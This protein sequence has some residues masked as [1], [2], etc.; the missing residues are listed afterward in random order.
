MTRGG[1]PMT[2]DVLTH[3]LTDHLLSI[4]GIDLSNDAAVD[5]GLASFCGW[6]TKGT[7]YAIIKRRS[8]VLEIARNRVVVAII[9]ADERDHGRAA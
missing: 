6:H 1:F 7:R 2:T 3:A 4:E 8:A 9:A 5:A